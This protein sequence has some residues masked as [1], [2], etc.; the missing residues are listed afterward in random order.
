MQYLSAEQHRI[1]ALS[2]LGGHVGRATTWTHN[3][4]KPPEHASSANISLP[5][6]MKLDARGRTY[7]IGFR[8]AVN[9][10]PPRS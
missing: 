5:Q 10:I 1:T 3:V 7:P 4:R 9:V 8:T 2:P 6:K